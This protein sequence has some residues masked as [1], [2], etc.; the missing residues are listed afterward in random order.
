MFY[1]SW[2]TEKYPWTTFHEQ[3]LTWLISEVERL[4]AEMEYYKKLDK[5]IEELKQLIENYTDM[6][7]AILGRDL[8][9]DANY[10]LYAQVVPFNSRRFDPDVTAQGFCIGEANGRPVALNLFL[11][12]GNDNVAAIFT[13]MDDGSEM[14]RHVAL[15][16]GHANS[17]CYC[18]ETKKFYVACDGESNPSRRTLVETD[19]N[20]SIIRETQIDGQNVWAVTSAN[21]YLYCLTAGGWLAKVE[22]ATL[23]MIEKYQFDYPIGFI[24]QGLFADKYHLYLVNGNNITGD[25]DI[26]NINRIT[27]M[28]FTGKA[29]KQIYSA[30]PLEMEEG[31]IWNDELY[32]C[33]N[34][35]HCALI[36]KHDLY[37]KNRRCSFGRIYENV[38]VNNIP[39]NVYVNEQNFSFYMDGSTPAKGLSSIAWIT[40]WLRN[41][42][43]RVN[44][45][46]QTDITQMNKLSIRKYPNTVLSIDGQGHLMPNLLLESM[47]DCYINS[48]IFPGISGTGNYTIEYHG[49]RLVV[50]SCQFGTVNKVDPNDESTWI[51]S[52]VKPERLIF[53]TCPFEI[54]GIE[55]YQDADFFMYALGDGYLKNVNF[56]PYTNN[57]R[58]KFFAGN[59]SIDGNFNFWMIRAS[60]NIDQINSCMLFTSS[61]NK[62]FSINDIGYSCMIAQVGGTIDDL[63]AGMVRTDLI[64]IRATRYR[65]STSANNMLFEFIKTDGTV[66][67]ERRTV[68]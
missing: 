37:C 54:N 25:A 45:Y 33:S 19:F 48:C 57:F 13:Y 7:N 40:I 34:T 32:V 38:E 9:D 17:C 14:G 41:S 61:Y 55:V 22:P 66:V 47:D 31:D 50:N 59:T 2:L 65:S 21:G 42:T 63:P 39:I 23:N 18:P 62:T 46:I 35:T 6:I 12:G 43:T 52:S 16:W 27:V 58:Y 44:L 60:N 15:P 3:N 67:I 56:Y 53:C 49:S 8:V 64:A 26:L 36:V 5:D 20:G 28:D 11:D 51:K 68:V 4:K 30:F 10:N 29:I 1:S 24:A